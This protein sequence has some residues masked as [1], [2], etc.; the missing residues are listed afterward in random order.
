MTGHRTPCSQ[1]NVYRF[2]FLYRHDRR[3][4]KGWFAILAVIHKILFMYH[5]CTQVIANMTVGKD[6]AML[7]TDVINCIQT[8]EARGE[9]KHD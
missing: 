6:V 2:F 3:T 8:G 7:F 4:Y 5:T 1:V 9:A